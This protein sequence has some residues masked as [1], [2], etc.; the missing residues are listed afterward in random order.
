M[1]LWERRD[2]KGKTARFTVFKKGRDLLRNEKRA[3]NSNSAKGVKS[4]TKKVLEKG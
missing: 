1:S 2:R 3:H 4:L